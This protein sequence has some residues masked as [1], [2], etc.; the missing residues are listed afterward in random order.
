M[1]LCLDIGNTNIYVG[2]Y[3]GKKITH[4]FRI[5]TKQ[6]WTS[7]Q[8]GVFIRSYLR[9]QGLNYQLVKKIAICSVVPSV[10]YSIRSACIKYF[11]I[12]PFMVQ[13]GVKTGLIVNKYKNPHEVGSD[14]I[15]GCVAATHL[16][17]KQNIIVVDLGTA[18]TI[19]AVNDK[20]EFY[21]GVIIPGIKTQ[22]DSL[23]TAAEKLSAINIIAPE[24][25]TGS[26]TTH[27]IQ[28]GIYYGHLAAISKLS[29]QISLEVFGT[30]QDVKIVGTGG[31][32]TLY[33]RAKLFDVID[34]DLIINGL[35]IIEKLNNSSLE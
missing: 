19:A 22:A 25:V 1:M 8:F 13:L 2:Y 11:G 35:I 33:N 34:S 17:P 6:S 9:E 31:F 3:D 14:I 32:A 4:N 20:K 26:S 15:A 16:F 23:F 7:D 30:K 29:D 10:N 21:G 18:T 5:T 27:A 24:T 12:E 28:S